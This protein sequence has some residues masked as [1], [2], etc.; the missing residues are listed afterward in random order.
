MCVIITLTTSALMSGFLPVLI[1]LG[2]FSPGKMIEILREP[3]GDEPTL[4]EVP[5]VLVVG[6]AAAAAT[7]GGESDE[8]TGN[9]ER[10]EN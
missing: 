7:I 8:A 9:M 5:P 3:E 2:F 1:I 4:N 10:G 6:V